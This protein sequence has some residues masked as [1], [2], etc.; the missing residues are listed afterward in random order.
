[1]SELVS[2]SGGPCRPGL[3]APV[4][5]AVPSPAASWSRLSPASPGLC[6]HPW[7]P[8]EARASPRAAGPLQLEAGG[9]PPSVSPHLPLPSSPQDSR[10]YLVFPHDSSALSSSFH[11]LQLFDQD[12]SN[13]V[14]VSVA[15]PGRAAVGGEGWSPRWARQ[16]GLE[17]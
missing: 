1:M 14:S 10:L 3:A 4:T 15:V 16:G 12:S 9:N 2:L 6:A 11:H 17:P 5:E 8:A 13:V 7:G